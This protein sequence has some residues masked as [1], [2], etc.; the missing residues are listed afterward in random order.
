MVLSAIELRSF[1]GLLKSVR[2]L[3]NNLVV[4]ILKNIV[5]IN[6]VVCSGV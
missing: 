2:A 5:I 1:L 6:A 4:L 3:S